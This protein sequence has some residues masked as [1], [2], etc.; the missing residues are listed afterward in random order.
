MKSLSGPSIKAKDPL[1]DPLFDTLFDPVFDPPYRGNYCSGGKAA[2]AAGAAGTARA[3]ARMWSGG[4][5]RC[6]LARLEMPPP[7]LCRL[8]SRHANP[9]HC[10]ICRYALTRLEAVCRAHPG[11]P[12]HVIHSFFAGALLTRLDMLSHNVL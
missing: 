3:W 1:F 6:A 7:P 5:G 10:R 9:P 2:A 11:T 12:T 8:T 4:W